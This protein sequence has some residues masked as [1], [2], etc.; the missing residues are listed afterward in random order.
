MSLKTRRTPLSVKLSLAIS[1]LLGLL[2]VILSALKVGHEV[3][4]VGFIVPDLLHDL[5]IAFIVSSSVA[6]LFEIYRSNR[7]QME[8]M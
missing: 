1:L 6:G 3:R 8:A 5:G 4:Y 7:H 2:L